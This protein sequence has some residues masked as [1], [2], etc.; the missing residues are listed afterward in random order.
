VSLDINT[1]KGQQTLEQERRLVQII[2]KA[3]PGIAYLHT[4]K[5]KPAMV[6]AILSVD[7]VMKAVAQASCR[8]L[9]RDTLQNRYGNEWLLTYEKMIEGRK[10]AVALCVDYWGFVYLAPDDIAVCVKMFSP[11]RGWLVRFHVAKTET[12]ATCNG[13]SAVRDNAY[14]D[15]SGAIVV[16]ALGKR[17]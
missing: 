1:P 14:I 16:D 7:N 11:E 12:Q 4:P 10:L 9:T 8:N 6:D 2:T 17:I 15:V 3:F 5:D 13:G